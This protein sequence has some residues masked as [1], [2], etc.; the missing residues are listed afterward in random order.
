MTIA[1]WC[2]F[3]AWLSIYLPRIIALREQATRPEG[4]DNNDPRDQQ[5]KLDVRGRRANAAHANGFE[6][7]PPFAAAVVLS[8]VVGGPQD[9]ANI[10][11]VTFVVARLVYPFLYVAGLGTG[12]TLVWSVGFLS[13]FALFLVPTVVG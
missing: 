4:L 6:A 1:L 10:F 12:R 11:A 3:P 8:H 5:A 9:A 13:T 2:L 7:F